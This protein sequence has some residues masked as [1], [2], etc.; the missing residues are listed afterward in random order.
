MVLVGDD[1]QIGA[2]EAG[3]MFAALV[4]DRDDL[5]PE[6]S[7]V[8]R[9]HHDWEKAASVELRRALPTPSTPTKRTGGSARATGTRCSTPSIG[10]GRHD[11]EAGRTSLMIAGDLGTVGELNGRAR[12]DRVAAGEVNEH[13]WPWPAEGRPGSATRWSPG[14]TTGVSPPAEGGCATATAGPSQPP[15]TMV[16]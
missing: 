10:R 11:T 12:A 9:F 4:R 7:D 13:G 8:R 14:R 15:T 2:V 1:R 6:L 5:A 3:G 16:A